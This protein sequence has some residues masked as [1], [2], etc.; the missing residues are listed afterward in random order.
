MK[1]VLPILLSLIILASNC[2]SVNAADSKLASA[3]SKSSTVIFGVAD[4]DANY[5]ENQSIILY[6]NS[7]EKIRIGVD[8]EIVEFESG[9]V[10]L[11][12]NPG[13]WSSGTIPQGS[14]V[15]LTPWIQNIFPAGD[16]HFSVYATYYKNNLIA[17]LSNI[18][19]GYCWQSL[20]FCNISSIDIYRENATTSLPAYAS[21]DFETRVFT[22]L[23]SHPGFLTIELN[24]NGQ[25]RVSWYLW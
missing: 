14:Y 4:V 1:R 5:T 10:P 22:A 20:N 8:I 15:K 6:S 24:R 12:S 17:N 18:S 19:T 7:K 11:N 25:I 13:Q 9:I 23:E 3:L 2:Y 21:M 16:I